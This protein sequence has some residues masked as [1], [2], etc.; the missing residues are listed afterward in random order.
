LLPACTAIA[1]HHDRLMTS[2][3]SHEETADDP[4][5]GEW[6][7]SFFVN[8]H[9]TPA[10]FVLKLDGD[11]ITGTANSDHT[12]LGTIRDGKFEK[13][14][15]SFTLDFQKHESIEI[16]GELKGDKL[17]GEFRTE[18]FVANWEATKK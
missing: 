6:N 1:R 3:F 9:S 7:V 13:G 2:H 17:A 15:L 18:G 16:N 12:G 8:G 10:S 11:K 4:I 14:K 5:S